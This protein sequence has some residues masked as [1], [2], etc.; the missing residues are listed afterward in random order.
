MDF[1]R[2]MAERDR[3][4]GSEILRVTWV[5]FWL[6]LFLSISKIMAGF[7][8]NSRAVV[9]DGVHS[10]SDLLTDIAVLIGVRFW[11]APPDKAHP[12][13]YKRLESLISLVIGAGLGLAGIGI[14][15]D[16]IGRI[17]THDSGK[18]GSLLALFATLFSVISK[19]ILYRW[20]SMKARDLKSDAMEANAW[21][22]RSDAISSIP[23][24]IAV[25]VSLWFPSL[26][27][28]D[29]LGAILVAGFILYAAWKICTSAAHVLMDGGTDAAVSAKI[30]EYAGR[31]PGV[32]GVHDLRTRFV[33]QGLQVD[34]HV[35]I[36]ATL[37]IGEGN[38]IAHRLEDSL[39][40][41]DAAQYVGV[42][43]F[44]ALVHIDP[45]YPHDEE[46]IR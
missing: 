45:W 39:Y 1:K 36:D 34:M 13:G 30:V 29:L 24:C 14:A 26:A 19:E 25:A 5:G 44:D 21:D 43:I 27:M 2:G 7:L 18:V 20:T 12:Y 35:C 28:V 6:N 33:G 11:M 15:W 22:H 38:E 37:S 41:A 16:A 10:L 17:G 3:W 9:A 8:G 23:V 31:T 32:R 40:T 4:R 42:E 46:D